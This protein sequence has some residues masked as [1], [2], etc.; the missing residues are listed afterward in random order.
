M[1]SINS[2]VRAGTE[3]FVEEALDEF[4]NQFIV[5][6]SLDS[7]DT[8]DRKIS[9]AMYA[10]LIG[11]IMGQGAAGARSIINKNNREVSRIFMAQEEDAL[12]CFERKVDLL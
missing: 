5:D 12:K 8:N 1:I 10:G 7:R 2:F 6:A 4:V 3:E 11:G 9:G